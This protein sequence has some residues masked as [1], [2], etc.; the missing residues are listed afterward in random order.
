MA[1]T[2]VTTEMERQIYAATKKQGVFGCFEVTI[3]WFG[4]ERVDYLTLDTKGIWRCYE[5]KVS[6]SDFRSKANKTFCGH[7]NYYVMPRELYEKV[8]GEIPSHIGVYI[9]G[10]LEKRAK[11]QELAVEEDVLKA[12]LIR[13]LSREADKLI[14]SDNPSTVESLQRQIRYERKQKEEYRRMYQEERRKQKPRSKATS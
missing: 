1:K 13:S 7:Y 8:K 12:S 10:W 2:E 4:K 9:G 3:G 14:K 11:K 5:V 6:V